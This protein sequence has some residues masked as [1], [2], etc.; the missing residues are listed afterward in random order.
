MGEEICLLLRCC[1]L[2][3]LFFKKK[4]QECQ[5]NDPLHSF[6]SL[7]ITLLHSDI[8]LYNCNYQ[9]F[10]SKSALNQRWKPKVSGVKKNQHWAA[11]ISSKFSVLN[12]PDSATIRAGQLWIRADDRWCFSSFLNQTENL[13]ISETSL[14]SADY[15]W[16]YNPGKL[17]GVKTC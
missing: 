1:Q 3:L 14:F 2:S 16:A 8:L 15:L 6:A 4:N 11:L 17:R 9:S 5:F 7:L 13:E 10:Q 12:N